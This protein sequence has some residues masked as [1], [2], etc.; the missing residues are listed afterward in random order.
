M[1]KNTQDNLVQSVINVETSGNRAQNSTI[2]EVNRQEHRMTYILPSD[3]FFNTG[4]Y[5]ENNNAGTLAISVPWMEHEHAHS[6]QTGRQS[7]SSSRVYTQH[8]GHQ[9]FEEIPQS[10]YKPRGILVQDPLHSDIAPKLLT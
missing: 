1:Y 10:H 7:N 2:S 9:V 8:V 3:R 6:Q 4:V 5:H